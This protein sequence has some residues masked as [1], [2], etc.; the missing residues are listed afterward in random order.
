MTCLVEFKACGFPQ[1]FDT[2]LSLCDR[3]LDFSLM[4]QIIR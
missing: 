1:T 2:R 3:T 4:A